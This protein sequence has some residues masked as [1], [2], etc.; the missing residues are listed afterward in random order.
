[1]K[2][3]FVSSDYCFFKLLTILLQSQPRMMKDVTSIILLAL[4]ITDVSMNVA[5]YK[6]ASVNHKEQRNTPSSTKSDENAIEYYRLKVLEN[7]A[8]ELEKAVALQHLDD[9]LSDEE[10]ATGT[11][12]SEHIPGVYLYRSKFLELFRSDKSCLR[13]PKYRSVIESIRS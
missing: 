1:M 11:E 13:G 5:S 2:H 7:E 3:W 10:T 8:I 4:I 12:T 6:H 9:M